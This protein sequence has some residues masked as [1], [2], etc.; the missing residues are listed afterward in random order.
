MKKEKP[1]DKIMEIA[2]ALHNWYEQASDIFQWETQKECRVSFDKLPD[3]N[4]LVMFSVA[5][6]VYGNFMKPD[7]KFGDR[8]F[9]DGYKKAIRIINEIT[10][11]NEEAFSF[12]EYILEELKKEKLK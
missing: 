11:T 6:K 8:R 4:K 2:E 12:K 3:N 1:K 10:P 9:K 5:E 7:F